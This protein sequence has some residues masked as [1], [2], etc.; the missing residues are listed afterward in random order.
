MS[1]SAAFLAAIRGP[2]LLV[3]LGVLFLVD[4]S[5]GY[6]F[7]QT[8]PVLVIL[9]GL[10]KLLERAFPTGPARSTPREGGTR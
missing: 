2:L 10:L 4:R 1:T 5:G 9:Y 8:W 7:G 6:S 3:A